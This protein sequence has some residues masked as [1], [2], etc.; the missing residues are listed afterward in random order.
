[1]SLVGMKIGNYNII[2]Q[3]GEGGMGA[4]YLGEHPLI[5]KKVAV[6]VLHDQLAQKKDI[7]QRFFT[8]A[9]AVND[10][11]HENIVDIVDFGQMKDDHGKEVVYFI[12]ELLEGDSLSARLKKGLLSPQQ[13]V[14]ITV[15]CAGA[16][17]MSH[18]H[19]IVHRDI[20][21]DNIYLVRRGNDE[22]FCKLLDFGIA[23]LTGDDTQANTGMTRAGSVIG[24]PSYMSPEQC[25]G[26]GNIDHRADIYSLGIVLYEML[27]GQVPFPGEGFGEVLVAQ[28]T[29]VPTPPSQINPNV[30]AVLEQIVM[31]CLEKQKD[32]RFQTMDELRDALMNT[33]AYVP[34]RAPTGLMA[35]IDPGAIPALGSPTGQRPTTLSGAAAEASSR[36]PAKKS[37]VA[38]IA[39]LSGLI[40]VGGV[41]AAVMA[42]SANNPPPVQPAQI[43]PPPVEPKVESVLVLID[44]TPQGAT[45]LRAGQPTPLGKTP[46]EMKLKKGTPSFDVLLTFEGYK[47]E[48]RTVSTERDRDVLVAM[49]KLEVPVQAPEPS[50]VSSGRGSGSRT[51]ARELPRLP[52]DDEPERKKGGDVDPDGVLAPK[53]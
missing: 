16:L 8:E 17:A 10:I 24:T 39:G 37:P 25:D 34:P 29:Q 38:L 14:H 50:K 3:L 46:H 52:K 18:S 47:S 21:P 11:H 4:V 30:P 27:A 20:K 1:M 40:V 44:S 19:H 22:H 43:A 13:A 31:R 7:V 26:K 12:M 9:K 33:D 32:L 49:T 28:L 6:K 45:V 53:L 35:I 42:R 2:K 48:T 51:G 15:Q 23:K 5:G 36:P 41:V